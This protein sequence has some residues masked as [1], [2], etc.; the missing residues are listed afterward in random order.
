MPFCITMQ[1]SHR[2]AVGQD[3]LVSLK[4]GTIAEGQRGEGALFQRKRRESACKIC[5]RA[6]QEKLKIHADIW[7]MDVDQGPNPER[8]IT[9]KIY[10]KFIL[11]ARVTQIAS[12]L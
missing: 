6:L 3:V 11:K 1:C 10:S 8:K 12:G 7:S 9:T 5:R 4:E 2:I